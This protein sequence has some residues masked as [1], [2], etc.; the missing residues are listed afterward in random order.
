MEKVIC[1]N[2]RKAI[3]QQNQIKVGKEFILTYLLLMEILKVT[4][5]DK[6]MQMI[7]KKHI[8]DI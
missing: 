3:S 6:Y 7:R 8:L 1:I 4:G 5:M 2:E